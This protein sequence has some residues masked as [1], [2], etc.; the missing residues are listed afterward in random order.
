[1]SKDTGFDARDIEWNSK[2][3]GKDIEFGKEKLDQNSSQGN[4]NCNSVMGF[5]SSLQE[6]SVQENLLESSIDKNLFTLQKTVCA[7]KVGMNLGFTSSLL[8]V[9]QLLFYYWF[10]FE[11]MIN[12]VNDN[13]ALGLF[14][15][16]I[17]TIIIV[18]LTIYIAYLSK[19]AVGDYTAKALK[20]FFIGKMT[21]TFAIGFVIFVSFVYL[22]Y[23]LDKISF[24]STMIYAKNMFYSDINTI[25][26]VTV[27]LIL[28]S[29]FLPFLFY[30]F[31]KI[32]FSTSEKA[33]YD[34][35]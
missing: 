32:L 15:K 11:F 7:L 22:R 30:G 18:S 28:I 10:S 33:K 9:V 13:I 3:Y 1:M 29:S 20:T 24:N 17:P 23:L 12:L 2:G 21:S 8:I 34:K 25:Y 35:Y 26:Y 5:I 4:I 19:Y 14:I 31:R 27:I 6:I 16:Y